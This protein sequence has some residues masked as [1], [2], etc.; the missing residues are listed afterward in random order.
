MA[1]GSWQG[2]LCLNTGACTLEFCQGCFLGRFDERGP[3]VEHR[4][5]MILMPGRLALKVRS[6]S[7]FFNVYLLQKAAPCGSCPRILSKFTIK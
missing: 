4:L 3:Y 7:V 5:R 6:R 1:Q 2:L